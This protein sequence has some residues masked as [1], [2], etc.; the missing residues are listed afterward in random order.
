MTD[1]DFRTVIRV[2]NELLE[3]SRVSKDDWIAILNMQQLLALRHK[4]SLQ[5]AAS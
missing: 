4:Q 3:D 1:A 2:L 5:E